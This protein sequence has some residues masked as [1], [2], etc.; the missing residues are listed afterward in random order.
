MSESPDPVGLRPLVVDEDQS[1][2]FPDLIKLVFVFELRPNSREK[3]SLQLHSASK[4]VPREL[5]SVVLLCSTTSLPHFPKMF[6]EKKDS[7][8]ATCDSSFFVFPEKA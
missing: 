8:Q 2:E 1:N 7:K 3:K 6:R 4:K 5:R